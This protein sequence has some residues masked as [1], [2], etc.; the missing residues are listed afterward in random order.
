MLHGEEQRC[1]IGMRLGVNEV[2]FA[3][4]MLLTGFTHCE[5]QLS[6]PGGGS[7]WSKCRGR[8]T[9]DGGD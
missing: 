2:F 7:G 4:H 5:I 9:G 8:S 6:L 3:M 1:E